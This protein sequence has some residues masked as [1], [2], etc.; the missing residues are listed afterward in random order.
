[1]NRLRL[2]VLLAMGL[3]SVTS[4]GA[5]QKPLLP[6]NVAS[7]DVTATTIRG[8]IKTKVGR[9]IVRVNVSLESRDHKMGELLA[10][11]TMTDEK[12]EF[13]FDNIEPGSYR[14]SAEKQGWESEKQLVTVQ[15]DAADEEMAVARV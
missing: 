10:V 3:V 15:E 4:W 13:R 2:S 1:M 5:D 8:G 6:L 7:T 14:V 11:T 9:P 12:G